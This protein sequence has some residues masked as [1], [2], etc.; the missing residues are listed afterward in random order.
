MVQ[1]K[2]FTCSQCGVFWKIK[3]RVMCGEQQLCIRCY[4]SVTSFRSLNKANRAAAIEWKAT[5]KRKAYSWTEEQVLR[6][7]WKH[8]KLSETQIQDRLHQLKEKVL[9]NNKKICKEQK[10]SEKK[11]T[12]AQKFTE[13]THGI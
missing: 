6:N 12:F 1:H 5:H 9:D 4:R 3:S 2:R 11:I 10:E 7:Q 13:M 8:E